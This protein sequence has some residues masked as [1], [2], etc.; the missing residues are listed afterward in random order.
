MVHL[1]LRTDGMQGS[2]EPGDEPWRTSDHARLIHQIIHPDD[3][4]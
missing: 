1:R 2:V 3:D 4:A